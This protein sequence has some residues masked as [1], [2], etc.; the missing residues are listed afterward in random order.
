VSSL[1]AGL[2]Q[3]LMDVE[4]IKQLKARYCRFV[5]TKQWQ[6]LRTL[7]TED[8]RFEGL[9]SAPSGADVDGFVEGIST[10]LHDA[11]S[12]HHCHMPEI[13]FTGPATA[14]GVWA[15]M[16]YLEWPAGASPREAPGHRGFSGFGHYEEEYR[17]D[18]AEWKIAFLRLTRL[19]IDPLADGN[20]APRPGMLT[21][22][23]DWLGTV[24]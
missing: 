23:D 20:P 13:V 21:A 22:S 8:A 4:Q 6:R 5:D 12:I 3:Q 9:G 18:G 19:R 14:R 2:A 16:D 17:K 24:P 15:M 1:D 11:I 10:R 7:F